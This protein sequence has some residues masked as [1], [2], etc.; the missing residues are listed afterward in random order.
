MCNLGGMG[1]AM[2]CDRLFKSKQASR[3]MKKFYKHF[4]ED[5]FT[6]GGSCIPIK[7]GL[8]G[9]TIPGLCGIIGDCS[10]ALSCSPFMPTLAKRMWLIASKETIRYDKDG[11]IGLI[12]LK[13]A[14]KIDGGNYKPREYGSYA[15]FAPAAAEWG[16]EKIARDCIAKVD[17][18]TGIQTNPATGAK[19]NKEMSVLTEG[20]F[21]PLY[22]DVVFSGIDPDPCI[23]VCSYVLES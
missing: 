5:F 17:E 23:Q 4:E 13:G 21:S 20:E 15:V 19:W 7:S 11:N 6:A 1:G 2:V 8:T 3:I 16:D 14:D 22:K 18:L 9:F 12:N 10:N